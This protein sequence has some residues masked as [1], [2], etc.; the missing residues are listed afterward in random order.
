MNPNLKHLMPR[1]GLLALLA[2]CGT[3]NNPVAPVIVPPL[4]SIV[5]TPASD[6]LDVGESR[7]FTAVAVD[8]AGDAYTGSLRWTSTDA[9]VF[10]VSSSGLVRAQGEGSARL[11]VSGG[12]Q[13]DTAAVL[14]YPTAGGWVVQTSNAV[15]DLHDV[16]CD[17]D[18][19]RAWVVGSG[20]LVLS[21]TNAGATWT[22]LVPTTYDLRGVWFTSA[23]E[24]WAVGGGGTVLHTLD[25]GGSWTRLATVGS[26]EDL[27]DV[28]FASRDVGW[29]VGTNGQILA[30]SDR[31][32]T[33]SRT[34]RGGQTLN[35][36]M[37]AGADGWAVGENGVIVGSHDQGDSWFVVNPY[38][39]TQPLR[40]VWRRSE[41]QAVAV[42]SQGAVLRTAA[43][44]D[45][46][47]W[48]LGNAGSL[49][50]CAGVC[51]PAAGTGYAVGWN[52]SAGFVLRSDDGGSTWS[53]QTASSASALRGVFFVDERRGWAVGDDGVIRHTASG[54][55]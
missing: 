47:A 45:S 4:S 48:S 17:A 36:V 51:F 32:E 2:G 26:S 12:G 5:V 49:Y 23:T 52:G 43:T 30:T 39:T 6:T 8:T 20:G 31:G 33:W 44:A 25:G 24:G 14:V 37:F 38:V 34:W 16:F 13:A 22:R 46:V 21:T 53:P 35:G 7:L 50:Q 19:R 28:Y 10:T 29:A 42:G 11:I 18:G 55:E 3:D 41:E 40:A 1:L 15:E 54:G 27:R 9:G